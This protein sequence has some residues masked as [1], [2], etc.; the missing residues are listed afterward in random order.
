MTRFIRPALGLAVALGWLMAGTG[1]QAIVLGGKGAPQSEHCKSV[2]GTESGQFCQ[3]ENGSSCNS[4]T[5][6]RDGIC[7]DENGVL[8]EDGEDF[9]T[10]QAPDDS[11]DGDGGD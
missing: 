11:G 7:V 4:M 3:L 2:G 5:L 9:G 10:N 1:A 6:F 8:I